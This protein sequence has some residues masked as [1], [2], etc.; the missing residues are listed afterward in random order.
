MHSYAFGFEVNF[1]FFCLTELR[2]VH[3]ALFFGGAQNQKF[4]KANL[5]PEI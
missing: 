4:Q 5:S 2:L 1:I 3:T